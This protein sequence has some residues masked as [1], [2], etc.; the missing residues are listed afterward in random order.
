MFAYHKRDI[1]G[2]KASVKI[3]DSKWAKVRSPFSLPSARAHSIDIL[4]SSLQPSSH[5]RW[6]RPV[7]LV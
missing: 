1:A 3:A 6:K 7:R 4:P 2:N 5:S